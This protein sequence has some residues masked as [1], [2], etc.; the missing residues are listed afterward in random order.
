MSI[1]LARG[2]RGLLVLPSVAVAISGLSA[3]GGG[4]ANS[5]NSATTG[6]PEVPTGSPSPRRAPN[7]AASENEAQ[8]QPTSHPENLEEE[9]ESIGTEA[10]GSERTQILTTEHRYFRAVGDQDFHTA[11]SLLAAPT[12]QSL[13]ALAR[14]TQ[15]V[16]CSSILPRLVGGREATAVARAQLTGQVRKVR[17]KGK[18][19]IV[20]FHAPGARLY[21][22]SLVRQ[23][24]GWRMASLTGSVLAPSSATLGEG[25]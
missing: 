17:I 5:P 6:R 23:A 12:L 8:G 11:C 16:P 20:I 10:G 22:V 7:R 18:Q 9:V 4:S 19:G 24:G 15:S 2:A 14:Q 3:C 13:K 21:V 1:R 25:G